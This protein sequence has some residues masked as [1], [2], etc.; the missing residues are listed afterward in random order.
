[1]LVKFKP[2]FLKDLEVLPD[3]IHERVSTFVFD[4]LPAAESLRELQNIK[5]LHGF[6]D[7][8]RFKTGDYRVGFELRDKEI[9]VHRVLHRSKIYRYFP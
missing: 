5:R 6:K 4:T 3:D 9:I 8:Y 7:R 1:M 2:T